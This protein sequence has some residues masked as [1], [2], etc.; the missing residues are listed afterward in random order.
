MKNRLYFKPGSQNHRLLEALKQGSVYTQSRYGDPSLRF[1]YLSRRIKDVKEYLEPRGLTIIKTKLTPDNNKYH[2]APLPEK[3][4]W[5]QWL[6]SLLRKE[7]V[8]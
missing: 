7:Q 1:G 6:K 4:G 8:A 5:W 2:I 3:V